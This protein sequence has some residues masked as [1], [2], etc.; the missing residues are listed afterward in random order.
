MFRSVISAR[1]SELRAEE[2]KSFLALKKMMQQT[3][4]AFIDLPINTIALLMA[5]R[6][7]LLSQKLVGAIMNIKKTDEC[8]MTIIAGLHNL[9]SEKK[10][11]THDAQILDDNI[12][13]VVSN[14]YVVLNKLIARGETENFLSLVQQP[15]QKWS[16]FHQ[17][18]M[19]SSQQRLNISKQP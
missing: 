2:A 1:E 11:A 9:L 6:N 7:R 3:N 17:E 13:K 12:N 18:I 5:I 19:Q 16:V 10:D 14:L 4:P 15:Y 8:C